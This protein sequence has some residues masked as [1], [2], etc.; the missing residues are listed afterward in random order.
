MNCLA[1]LYLECENYHSYS[2]TLLTQAL[3]KFFFTR[4]HLVT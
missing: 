4:L 1:I 2:F 3:K